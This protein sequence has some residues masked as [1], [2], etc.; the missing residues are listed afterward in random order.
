MPA[1]SYSATRRAPILP[2]RVAGSHWGIALA[3]KE[4]AMR[5]RYL[6][7]ALPLLVGAVPPSVADVGVSVAISVPG[8]QIGINVPAYPNLVPVPGYPV[9]YAPALPANYFF[10]DGLYWVYAGGR[11]YSSDWY[12]GPW[13]PVAP[14]FVPLF[15]LRVPVRYYMRPPGYFHAWRPDAPPHWGWRFGPQWE[16]HHRDWARWN[17]RETPA[18]APLPV[19]QRDYAGGR[20]P[21]REQQQAIRREHYRFEPRDPR[22][23]QVDAQVRQAEARPIA[24]GPRIMPRPEGIAQAGRPAPQTFEPHRPPPQPADPAWQQRQPAVEPP[25]GPPMGRAERGREMMAQGA[26]P[27]RPQ[28][29]QREPERRGPEGNPHAREQRHD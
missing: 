6:T 26:E 20:Y 13:M 9:Y 5:Y 27:A 11:W 28:H 18:P 21:N 19:Y 22:A 4:A 24:P 15:V 10:Y 1:L 3:L 23:S 8:L 14:D 7:L 25:H 16:E 17:R 29:A 12:D 2:G